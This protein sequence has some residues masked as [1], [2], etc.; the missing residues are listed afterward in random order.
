MKNSLRKK[1]T[2]TK[3][4]EEMLYFNSDLEIFQLNKEILKDKKDAKKRREEDVEIK[5]LSKFT[6]KD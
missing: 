3:Y 6:Y 4:E 5:I 1:K 2:L